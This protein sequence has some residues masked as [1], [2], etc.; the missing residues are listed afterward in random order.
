MSKYCLVQ[1]YGNHEKFE[2]TERA[3]DGNEDG[4]VLCSLTSEKKEKKRKF[5][6]WKM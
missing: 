2:K 1:K 5:G 6:S 3:I 4:M